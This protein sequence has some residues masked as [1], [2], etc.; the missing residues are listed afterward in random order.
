MKDFT[1]I[2]TENGTPKKET[3]LVKEWGKEWKEKKKRKESKILHRNRNYK[4]LHLKKSFTY[5]FTSVLLLAEV[6]NIKT[7]KSQEAK[8]QDILEQLCYIIYLLWFVK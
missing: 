5:I 8:I 7:K 6:K 3:R 1:W 4:Q 2:F